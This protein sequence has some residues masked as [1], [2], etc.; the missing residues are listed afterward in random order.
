MK[1]L[2]HSFMKYWVA[3]SRAEFSIAR[4]KG[5]QFLLNK[6]NWIDKR[7]LNFKPYE[8]ANVA[9]M[10]AIIR[11]Q[12]IATF[13]DIGANIG[14]YSVLLGKEP[15]IK[16]VHAF[17]PLKRNYLQLGAN[18]LINGLDAVVQC[19]H[20]A[21]GEDNTALT[22]H[23]HPESTGIAT[24][25][26]NNTGRPD[27]D[28]NQ[29]EVV[30]CRVFDEEFTGSGETVLMK[31]DVEGFEQHVLKGMLQ[32][33]ANNTVYLVIEMNTAQ[34]DTHALLTSLGFTRLEREL[35]DFLYSNAKN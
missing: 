21:L 12:G 19:H 11:E 25:D 18:V 28:Y 13:Y 22:L 2:L 3:L 34:E 32:F 7:L 33:L 9:A 20:C 30:R 29:H 15:G 35:D 4:R 17:E 31:I 1:Q 23:Y 27:T 10:R 5:A 26:A 14:Y 16:Q 24:L 6:H 8:E